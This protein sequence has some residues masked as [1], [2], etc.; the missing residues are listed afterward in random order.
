MWNLND[1][2]QIEVSDIKTFNNATTYRRRVGFGKEA[3]KRETY[4]TVTVFDKSHD[5]RGVVK[6]FNIRNPFPAFVEKIRTDL[7]LWTIRQTEVMLKVSQ[8]GETIERKVK[9]TSVLLDM[10]S[11]QVEVTNSIDD[12]IKNLSSSMEILAW[13]RNGGMTWSVNAA[14]DDDDED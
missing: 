4:V 13:S 7:S 2:M 3:K 6:S 5:L 9:L 12:Q 11:G 1:Y 10:P 8:D 14:D